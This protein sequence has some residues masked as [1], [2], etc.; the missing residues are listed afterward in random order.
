[1]SKRA[2]TSP[3]GPPALGPY[4]PAIRSGN[5]VFVSGQIPI[6]PAS[7]ELIPEKDI[8]S[9]TRRVLLNM[10]ALLAAAGATLDQVVRTTVF[11]KDMNDCAGMNGAYS[12]FFTHT[13]PARATVEVA[14][15]P[16]DVGIEVDCI[17][18]LEE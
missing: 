2:I 17:A 10:Q 12:E 1:M 11:L 6:D 7:G 14:R 8:A 3:S 9:Q 15:L 13:P 18:M 16:K 5:F 4:S